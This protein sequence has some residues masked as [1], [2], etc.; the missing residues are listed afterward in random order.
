MERLLCLDAASGRTLWEYRR[1]TP[2]LVDYPAG[3]RATPTVHDGLVY[4]LGIQGRLAFTAA[5][6]AA[7]VTHEMAR[8]VVHL[9]DPSVGRRLDTSA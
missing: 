7:K 6:K 9:L 8:E 1:N 5:T 2:C 3:P 4:F